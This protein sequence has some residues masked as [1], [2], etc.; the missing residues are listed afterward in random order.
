MS[1]PSPR[2]CAMATRLAWTPSGEIAFSDDLAQTPIDG[3]TPEAQAIRATRVEVTAAQVTRCGAVFAPVA[4]VQLVPTAG[5]AQQTR[6][7]PMAASYSQRRIVLHEVAA[8]A[9]HGVPVSLVGAPVNVR[10]MVIGDED[11]RVLGLLHAA[12]AL[13]RLALLDDHLDRPAAI[14]VGTGVQRVAQHILGRSSSSAVASAARSAH[15]RPCSPA[16]RCALRGTSGASGGCCPVP[17]TG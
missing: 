12:L 11:A 7:Q 3:G 2:D 15:A 4:D 6:Q 14:D 5:T 10:L 9:S 16:A 8:V 13:D 17:R 1:L